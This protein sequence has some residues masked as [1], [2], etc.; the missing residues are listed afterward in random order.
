MSFIFGRALEPS[1]LFDRKEIVER[2]TERCASIKKGI[3]RDYAL[4]GPRRVGKTS[5]IKKVLHQLEKKGINTV[6]F[7]CQGLEYGFEELD[8]KLFIKLYGASVLERF[9]E[10]RGIKENIVENIKELPS[11]TVMFLAELLGK[12]KGL[13][14]DILNEWLSITLEFEKKAPSQQELLDYFE[15]TLNL[16]EELAKR[17]KSYWVISFD[18]FQIFASLKIGTK[19]TLS[20][21]RKNFENHKR[22]SYIISGSN[23]GLMQELILNLKSPFGANF[24]IEWIGAFDYETSKQFLI[25]NFE[26]ERVKVEEGAIDEIINFTGGY[27]AYL[28]WF[29]EKCIQKK[30]VKLQVVKDIE[31]DIFQPYNLGYL[32]EREVSRLKRVRMLSKTYK[33]LLVMAKYNLNSPSQIARI[34][35]VDPSDVINYLNRL[36]LYGYVIK[37]K[38]GEY[39]ILDKLLAKYLASQF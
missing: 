9:F 29:G 26:D 1:Q 4:V 8:I 28:N 20:I 10:K 30:N 38:E 23:V 32:F 17:S 22:I 14:M 2:L 16:P 31:K 12:I 3:R 19:N 39:E 13:K 33:V 6:L 36:K 25:K 35:E 5:I 15:R 21:L 18:E 7:D 34:M 11:R 24:F 27:P 37:I